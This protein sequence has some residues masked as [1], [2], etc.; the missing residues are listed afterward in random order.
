MINTKARKETTR[1]INSGTF[2]PVIS[3][4]CAR[5]LARFSARIYTMVK[6]IAERKAA[7]FFITGK[8]RGLTRTE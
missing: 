2:T 8:S 5:Y 6:R 4:L 7:I 1:K 3:L